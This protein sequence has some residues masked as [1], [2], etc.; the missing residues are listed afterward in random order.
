M[1]AKLEGQVGVID[2]VRAAFME[3]R[4][5][6]MVEKRRVDNFTGFCVATVGHCGGGGGGG[7]E[8][9]G[10]ASCIL[11]RDNMGAT[12]GNGCGNHMFSRCR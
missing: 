4:Q 11:W 2:A 9:N 6:L 5:E 12:E 8:A 10:G 7:T 3:A 1:A